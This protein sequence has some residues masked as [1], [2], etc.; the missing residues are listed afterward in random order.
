APALTAGEPIGP[1]GGPRPAA[2]TSGLPLARSVCWLAALKVIGA[3]LDRFH[4]GLHPAAAPP[5]PGEASL[6]WRSN[7]ALVT[8]C[9]WP[10]RRW[11]LVVLVRKVELL[12][13]EL[14]LRVADHTG[15]LSA[16][17]DPR[18]ASVRAGAL[19][20][21]SALL[22]AGAVATPATSSG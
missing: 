2:A 17:V 9:P 1:A 19:C 5:P 11:H 21:G 20:E 10:P 3:P 14:S 8:R 13:G 6:L 12:A 4:L 22:L 7:V 15:E 16:S 18:I